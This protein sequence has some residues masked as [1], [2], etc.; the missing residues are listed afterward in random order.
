MK[1]PIKIRIAGMAFLLS[2]FAIGVLH[3]QD[4]EAPPE[5]TA[6]APPS[7]I[8][9]P[10]VDTDSDGTNDAWDVNGDG[11]TDIWDMNG[12]GKPDAWD[13]DGDGKPDAFDTDG[14]GKPDST[15]MPNPETEASEE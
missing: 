2:P 12:D 8:P 13:R 3:A 15:D 4:T 1:T 9:P 10:N 7:D 11:K 6:K 14:D 5:K